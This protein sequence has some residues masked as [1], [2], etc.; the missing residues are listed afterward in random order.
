MRLT[1]TAKNTKRISEFVAAVAV[2]LAASNSFFGKKALLK[3]S[4]VLLWLR[5]L[6][7]CGAVVTVEIDLQSV[8]NIGA[9]VL[10]EVDGV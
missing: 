4:E 3:D 9:D 10:A 6:E 7:S 8:A 2:L 1:H 5:R